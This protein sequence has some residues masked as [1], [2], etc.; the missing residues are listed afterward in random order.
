M[1]YIYFFVHNKLQLDHVY[2]PYHFRRKSNDS[3]LIA[4]HFLSPNSMKL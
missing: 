1:I 2:E 3:T 4:S